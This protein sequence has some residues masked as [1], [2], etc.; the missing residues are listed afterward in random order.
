M[1]LLDPEPE[2]RDEARPNRGVYLLPS[3]F[4]VGTLVCGYLAILATLKGAQALSSHS[5]N[6]YA[7]FDDAAIKI[8]WAFV[9][10]ALDGR[11]ARLTNAASNFGKEFDSLADIIA[12]G[13]APALLAYAWGIEAI[14]TGYGAPLVLIYTQRAGWLVGFA[15]LIC[16]AVRLARFNIDRGA[17]ADRRYF[18]GLPIPAAAGMV[19]AV[20]HWGKYP[21]EHWIYGFVWLLIVAAAAYLMISKVR[22]YSF[23]VMDLRKKRSHLVIILMG[24]IVWAIWAY[25]EPVLLTLATV[26][27][28]SGPVMR[29]IWKF[30]PRPPASKTESVHSREV[31]VT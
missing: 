28:L 10:D 11:I 16:G 2:L 18:V 27:F 15:F 19:A 1:E 26:Y 6:S 9:F 17:T 3:L 25:S 14:H 4:T 7:F 21:V 12:F 23:K 22:Y 20:V 24:L 31:H 29:L 5:G 30:R 13:I 8:A